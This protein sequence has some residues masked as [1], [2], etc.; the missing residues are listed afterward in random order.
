MNILQHCNS[1]VEIPQALV[2]AHAQVDV[3]ERGV[4]GGVEDV[5]PEARE[6]LPRRPQLTVV[7]VGVVEPQHPG[8]LL[9]LLTEAAF[10]L[11]GRGEPGEVR[12]RGVDS[13]LV[14][15]GIAVAEAD[16]LVVREGA[17]ARDGFGGGVG[18]RARGKKA[19]LAFLVEVEG[20]AVEREASEDSG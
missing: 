13:D 8:L 3:G 2:K 19:G 1:L 16:L 11:G 6:R 17:G 12:W 5:L 7:E 14:Q 10:R 4:V 15:V 20:A 18:R 9:L